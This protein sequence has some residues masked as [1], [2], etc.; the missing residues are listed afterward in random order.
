M[1]LIQDPPAGGDPPPR[2]RCHKRRHYT[3]DS[4][5]AEM[6]RVEA[7]GRAKGDQR[8]IDCYH[9]GP[10]SQALGRDVWHIGHQTKEV[11]S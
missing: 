8:A 11:R 3:I 4:A 5:R 7:L 6:N 10:C 2:R 1:S 9:C